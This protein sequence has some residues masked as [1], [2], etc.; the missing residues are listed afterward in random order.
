MD[1]RAFFRRI[2]AND[3]GGVFLFHGE[4]EYIKH[5]ALNAL[6][7]A[8]EPD[9]RELNM[10]EYRAPLFLEIQQACETLPFFSER[11]LVICYDMADAEAKLIPEYAKTM[12]ES[13]TLVLYMRGNAKKE[14]IKLFGAAEVRFAAMEEGEAVRFLEKRARLRGVT[15]AP[16][17]LRRL[18]QMVGL[19]AHALENEFSKAADYVGAGAAIT[20]ETLHACVTPQVEYE[21]FRIVD[22]LVDGKKAEAL[23]AL[24]HVL[25]QDVGNA[26][27]LSHFFTRQLKGMLTARLLMQTGVREQDV[28]ARMGV[29]PWQARAAIRGAKRLSEES[30]RG[31]LSAISAVDYMQVSGQMPADRAME[32][33][34]LKYL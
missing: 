15:A 32:L 22:Q 34:I 20:D 12:Q 6:I 16:A 33:A 28:S 14:L 2:Q 27:M 19:E 26:F 29:K 8:L 1:H 11:R 25:K 31:A 7:G 4:E 30:L 10:A 3:I 13:T 18:V 21:S 17:V 5:S 9:S 24:R 23:R